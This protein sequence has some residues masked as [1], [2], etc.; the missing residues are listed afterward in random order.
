MHYEIL[1]KK[2]LEILPILN[3][4]KD[5]FYLAGGTGLALILGHRDSIDFDFFSN[6]H[7]DTQKLYYEILDVFN[8]KKI[9]KIQEEKDTLVF[10]LEDEIKIS[11]F[12]YPY[13]VIDKFI[14]EENFKIASIKDIACMKL[15]AIV[16]RSI[17]KDYVDLYFILQIES[18]TI[19]LKFL[20][21]KMPDLD[22]NLIL[23]SFV[24]FDDI[25]QEKILFKNNYTVSLNTIKSFF[26]TLVKSL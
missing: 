25:E 11:F 26:I 6:Q 19:L 18:L 3:K 23:K 16:N 5:R 17:L 9:T 10:I 7:F 24:Y 12:Y 2:R 14:D 21:N 15:S 20:K 22:Q 13:P 8:D 1:D 4:F